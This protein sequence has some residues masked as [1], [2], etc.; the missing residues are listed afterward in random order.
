M[1]VYLRMLENKH[2]VY[3]FK[4]RDGNTYE[5]AWSEWDGSCM[6]SRIPRLG[7]VEYSSPDGYDPDW[8][9][10]QRLVGEKYYGNN[11]RSV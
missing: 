9:D 11:S 4:K 10:M 8:S 7:T 3:D 1:F 2:V 6:C 5:V